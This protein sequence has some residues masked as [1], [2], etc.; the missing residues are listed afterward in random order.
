MSLYTY[1]RMK[2]T[3]V[4]L[5]VL[6]SGMV[7]LSCSRKK[8][9]TGTAFMPDMAYSRAYETYATVENLHE[10]GINYNATPV[11]GTVARGDMAV[12]IYKNDSL[13]YANSKNVKNPLT[14]LEATEYL[15]AARLY[16]VNCAICHGDKL[17]GNGPLW[18]GGDGPFPSA[19]PNLIS[20]PVATT[21]ADGTMFHSITY[22]KNMMGSYASQLNTKQ[23]WMIVNYI[24]EKQKLANAA[25][26][27][28]K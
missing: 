6:V 15:E 2:N 22:G 8:E 3:A 27:A 1:F 11:A 9:E 20:D 16:L 10:K 5:A 7:V 13:G 24:K 4:V 23:R 14:T 18:K 17:D 26:A 21:M 19:P 12:Y 28:K 25:A